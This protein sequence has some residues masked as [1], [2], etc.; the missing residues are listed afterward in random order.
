MVNHVTLIGRLGKDPEFIFTPN[1]TE[2]SKFSIATTEWIP[3]KNETGEKYNQRTEWH[4]IIAF[5]KMAKFIT[6]NVHKGNL[7]YIDGK[8]Q[9]TNYNDKEGKKQYITQVVV[10]S[11]KL[12]ENIKREDKALKPTES[13]DPFDE[14]ATEDG[15]IPF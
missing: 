10:N 8:L 14:Y 15:E 13:E 11:I 3:N 5:K 4:K 6:E 7:V 1:G 12:L 9:T 2:I